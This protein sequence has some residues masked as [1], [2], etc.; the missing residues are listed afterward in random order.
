MSDTATGRT[1]AGSAGQAGEGGL[2]RVPGR[3]RDLG[4]GARRRVL[5]TLGGAAL[6][7]PAAASVAPAL[8]P[9]PAR[10]QA[11]VEVTFYYPVAVGGAVTK[12]IDQLA[13]DFSTANPGIRVK[14]VYS[15]TYQESIVKAMTAVKSGQPP[16]MAV[17]LSTDMF[18]LI[19]ED[20]IVP[21]DGLASSAEDRKWLDGFYKAFMLNSRTDGKT[22]GVPFQRSTIV[23]YW[24]KALFKEAGLNPDKG[25]D[26]WAEMVDYAK[27][28]TKLDASGNVERWG[29]K[30]PSSGF[31]YWLFQGLTTPN[32][33]I[34]MNE[35]GNETYFDKPGSVEALQYW[36]DLSAKHK[37]MPGG[38]IEWGTTPKDFLEQKAAMIWTTT[39]NLTNIRS[40]ANFPFGVA[41]LPAA[42]RRG[43][44]TGG[45]NFYVFKKTTAAEQRASLQ[46][47]RWVT[48]PER[49]AQWS[50]ATGYVAVRPDAWE[51][52]TMRKY[53]ADVPAALV[54]R[55]QLEFSV[56]EL[57][58]HENQ[59]VTKALNDGLQAALTGA[60]Q[61]GPALAEAQREA[62][63][64][65]RSYKR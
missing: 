10:A 31:P 53:V 5:K 30:I 45:G 37:V 65:L 29:V 1:G 44:P 21:I 61:P 25:P 22:W 49:A 2:A 12:T 15:G 9:R 32:D 20:A 34:L 27:K 3:A 26:T 63:R 40:N 38:V 14:P 13:A 48:S 60:K 39:G 17:L 54:A 57:S 33:T 47:I 24:N 52:E 64:I 7:V 16:Q 36:V 56:A 28:L 18:S 59:R 62:T 19:D 58:T 55:D 11:P 50:I 4:Q 6:G 23:L 51:T 35:A 42:K 8:M 43:S 46:F 41:M